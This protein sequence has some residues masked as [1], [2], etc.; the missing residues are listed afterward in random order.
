MGWYTYIAN[1]SGQDIEVYLGL[2]GFGDDQKFTISAGVNKS[3]GRG[4]LCLFSI[5]LS[6]GDNHY[7]ESGDNRCQ[8][9]E[10]LLG[11]GGKIVKFDGY[12]GRP[13]GPI[14]Q[15]YPET[16]GVLAA[17]AFVAAPH[18]MVD[19]ADQRVAGIAV[20][21]QEGA[22]QA[23]ARIR[24]GACYEDILTTAEAEIGNDKLFA[25]LM[26]GPAEWAHQALH[27]VKL[28]DDQRQALTDKVNQGTTGSRRD[29]A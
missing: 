27:Y 9:W 4:G 2:G 8:N 14:Q 3:Y 28:S 26:S 6:P 24:S 15:E 11:P 19:Y 16:S 29:A 7:I 5:Q 13:P 20:A 18:A 1:Q 21:K 23:L 17:E 22:T 25:A 12:A 10:F